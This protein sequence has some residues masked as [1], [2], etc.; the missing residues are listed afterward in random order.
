VIKTITVAAY[1]RPENLALLL[2]SLKEQLLPLDDYRLYIRIDPGGKHFGAVKAIAETDGCAEVHCPRKHQGLNRNCYE[3]LRWAF[4][5]AGADF[6]VYLEDDFILSPDAFSLVEWYIRHEEEMRSY[7][8][9]KDVAAYC[10][11]IMANVQALL[12]NQATLDPEEVFLARTLQGWGFV[13]NKHQWTT[14][15]KPHW[16]AG[17]GTWDTFVYR[18][19]MSFQGVHSA[20]PALSRISN[21]GREEGHTSAKKYD[22]QMKGHRYNQSRQVYDFQL[23]GIKH[24]AR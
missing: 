16:F 18:Y 11:C 22:W 2:Q 13:T 3:T 21:S 14:Y 19:I 10:L 7:P 9:V 23:V 17:K 20:F 15:V 12:G 8:R 1:N 5:T 4:E 24:V 6:N